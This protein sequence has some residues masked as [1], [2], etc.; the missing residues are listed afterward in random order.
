VALDAISSSV[1][2]TVAGGTVCVIRYSGVV[3]V[4]A[5]QPE[6][7]LVALCRPDASLALI[8]MAVLNA[9]RVGANPSPGAAPATVASLSSTQARTLPPHLRRP[10]APNPQPKVQKTKLGIWG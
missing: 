5:R 2:D 9:S 6:V 8:R 10:P 1:F 4:V 3:I 7:S